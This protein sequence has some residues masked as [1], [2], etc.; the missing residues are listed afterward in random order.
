MELDLACVSNYLVLVEEHH[1]GRAAT[2]LHLTSSGLRLIPLLD[3][4]HMDMLLAHRRRD[5]REPIHALVQ[6]IGTT[7]AE[8]RT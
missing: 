3:A 2:R 7:F 4:P 8:N 5:H 1:F 6:A